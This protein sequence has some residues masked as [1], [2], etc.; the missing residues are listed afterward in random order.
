MSEIGALNALDRA[1][2]TRL[3]DMLESNLLA[4]P[5]SE[6][7]LRNLVDEAH[8]TSVSDLLTELSLQ[9]LSQKHLA[10]V[11]RTFAAGRSTVPTLTSMVDVVVSGPD[12]N[13]TARDT[14]VVTRQLFNQAE[15][16]VLVVGFAIYQGRDIFQALASRLD[17]EET[18]EVTL[19]VDV[20]RE[21]GNTSLS[22]QIVRRFTANFAENEWPGTRLPR[23]YYDPR[24]L[25]SGR[26]T[27]SA[28]HAKCVVIDGAE[29]LVTSANFTEAAQERNIELGLYIKSPIIAGQIESHFHSLIDNGHLR[30]MFTP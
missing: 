11:I 4:P 13:A 28:L 25:E 17:T 19:C 29:A 2:L 30:Q 20:Q 16:R 1:S 12:V 10:L 15:D 22:D 18:L 24:S 8:L 14:G 21:P 26:A 3:G 9:N 23:L 7:S 5:Y 27:R 6:F